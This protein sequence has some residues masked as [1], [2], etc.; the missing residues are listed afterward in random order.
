MRAGRG[1]SKAGCVL[2]QPNGCSDVPTNMII[3]NLMTP[4]GTPVL[5]I[6]FTTSTNM[7]LLLSSVAD[8]TKTKKD[9]LE[10]EEEEEDHLLCY[11][12]TNLRSMLD[13]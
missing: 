8:I 9:E 7:K 2:R 4:A 5:N 10:E 1:V 3:V 6:E 12:I 13:M 11:M